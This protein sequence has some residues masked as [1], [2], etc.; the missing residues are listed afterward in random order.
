MKEDKMD[1][2][3]V[4][5]QIIGPKKIKIKL[6]PEND[7]NNSNKFRIFFEICLAISSSMLGCLLSFLIKDLNYYLV[8]PF[9]LLLIAGCIVFMRLALKN[10]RGEDSK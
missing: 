10:L 6:I 3:T 1:T 5:P 7:F 4:K 8:C 9:L 2:I